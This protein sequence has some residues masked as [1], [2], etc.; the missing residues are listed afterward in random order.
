MYLLCEQVSVAVGGGEALLEPVHCN[1]VYSPLR[2]FEMRGFP[3][4]II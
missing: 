3:H 4:I 1:H 2:W